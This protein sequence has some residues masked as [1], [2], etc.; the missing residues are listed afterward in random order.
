MS[1]YD[2]VVKRIIREMENEGYMLT[3]IND[4]EEWHQHG[5]KDFLSNATSTDEAYLWFNNVDG[6]GII[7]Y[8]LVYG[9]ALCETI[10]DAYWKNAHDEEVTERVMDK[11]HDFYENKQRE[12][13]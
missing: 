8:W 6:E 11:V 9:N 5:S 3:R 12:Y 10:A 4:G 7:Y 13:A 1:K 2:K